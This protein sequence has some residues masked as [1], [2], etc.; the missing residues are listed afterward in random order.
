MVMSWLK[1]AMKCRGDD[2]WRKKNKERGVGDRERDEREI[3]VG[4]RAEREIDE[5]DERTKTNKK[6]LRK[7]GNSNQGHNRFFTVVTSALTTE[8][9]RKYD[10]GTNWIKIESSGTVL[11]KLKVQGLN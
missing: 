2:K 10:G 5:R 8:F 7:R 9:D 11:I 1:V 4:G 6:L 3:G